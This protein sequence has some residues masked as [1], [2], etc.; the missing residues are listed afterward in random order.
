RW[1]IDIDA[2]DY[3]LISGNV[4]YNWAGAGIMTEKGNESF[5]VIENNFVMRVNGIG[6]RADYPQC[7][8]LEGSGIWLSGPNNY[9]RNNVV[10]DVT[11]P[12]SYT[13]GYILYFGN[14]GTMGVPAFQGADPSV[15]GQFIMA[16]MNA[17]PILQ[18]SGNETYGVECGLTYWEVGCTQGVPNPVGQSVIKDFTVWGFFNLGIF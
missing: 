15:A 13:Y 14:T 2:S 16:N 17:T 10:T 4:V 5:N 1:G 11:G 7:F 9:V 8:G 6:L 12:Q 3:G 18:F